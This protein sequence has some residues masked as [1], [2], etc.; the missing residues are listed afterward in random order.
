MPLKKE[1][2]R[3]FH[4]GNCRFGDKCKFLHVTQQQP[5]SNN[6]FGFGSQNATPFQQQKPNPFGFGVQNSG[7]TNGAPNSG[8]FKPFENK[9][10]RSEQQQ[11]QSQAANHTC[12]DPD[13]C[14]RLF[15]EDFQNERPLW[16][17]TCYGHYK[18]LPC[19]ITGDISYEEL[20]ALA[21]DDAKRGISLQSIVERERNLVNSKAAEF[22][23]LLRNPYTK[24]TTPTQSNQNP[25]PIVAASSPSIAP[26]NSGVSSFQQSPPPNMSFGVRP[27]AT[28]N[29]GFGQFQNHPGPFGASNNSPGSFGTQIP[30]QGGGNFNIFG[31]GNHGMNSQATQFPSQTGG[32]PFA[33][34]PG[35]FGNIGMINQSPQV[36]GQNGGVSFTSNIGGFGTTG[37]NQVSLPSTSSVSPVTQTPPANN[38]SML[39]NGFGGA[40]GIQ[41]PLNNNL[42]ETSST[43]ASIW[44][45][46]EWTR[47]EIPEQPP[48]AAYVR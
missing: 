41:Q 13:S 17:L 45:K 38:S 26:Q 39:L 28:T 14:K 18:Y 47:G 16:K 29:S 5:K 43:D 36:P 19:D 46:A 20:R 37:M 11:N 4:R 7:P 10:T 32:N 48:P 42:Q 2:C 6:P 35:G 24:H 22:E 44:L 15:A 23:N 31:F 3:N 30:A 27:S 25:F 8:G 12:T 40:N 21:Y 1:A 9:W 33:P 34:S